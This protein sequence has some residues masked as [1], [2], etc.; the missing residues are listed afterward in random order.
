[1]GLGGRLDAV[2]VFEPD[3]AL[4]MSVAL[5]HMEYLGD[6]REKI[7]FEKAGIFRA[8]KPAIYAE[9]DPPQSLLTHAASIGARLLLRGRDFD[10]KQAANHWGYQ[11]PGGA[12]H[13]LPW[14]ALR[15]AY[16]LGN[17]AACIATLDV[18]RDRL[19]V[20]MNDIRSGLLTVENPGRF[21]VLPGQPLVILDVAHNPHAARAL[22][23]GLKSLP[24]GGRTLAVF[25]ML[26][27]KDVAGVIAVLKPLVAQWF[28]AGLSGPRGGTAEALAEKLAAADVTAVACFADVEAALKAARDVAG[29]DDKIIVFGSF[30]TVSEAMQAVQ[31]LQTRPLKT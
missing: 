17:A 6:T 10:I 1:V 16:Q 31:K 19:P 5:D 11:G 25:A 9:A 20:T 7:G 13:V 2:N 12:R 29:V 26:S 21:Q 22:A 27:D 8:G 28:V 18:L 30:Y 24:R 15:G 23:G 3:C 4:V 14:P